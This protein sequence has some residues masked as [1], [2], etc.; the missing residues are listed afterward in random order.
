[1]VLHSLKTP[2]CVKDLL[3]AGKAFCEGPALIPIVDTERGGVNQCI[4]FYY[5]FN[6]YNQ[7]L[8]QYF[9]LSHY[10]CMIISIV[11]IIISSSS[12]RKQSNTVHEIFTWKPKSWGENHGSLFKIVSQ[13][14][15]EGGNTP[16][17]QRLQ[18]L[19]LQ[20]EGGYD[21]LDLQATT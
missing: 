20:L 6:F 7:Q 12:H 11:I 3:Q 4:A 8:I 17:L 14:S 16:L 5:F 1:M 2:W 13:K 9:A 21:P 19:Q 18:F 10:H 15:L